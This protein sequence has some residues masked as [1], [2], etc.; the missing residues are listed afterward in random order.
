MAATVKRLEAV[1]AEALD[2]E[3]RPVPIA[4][5]A[6]LKDLSDVTYA[7]HGARQPWAFPGRTDSHMHELIDVAFLDGSQELAESPNAW[8]AFVG[9][10]FAGYI[11]LS[12]WARPGY[13]GVTT[14]TICD[15]CVVPEFR[16]Q[17]VG[18]ALLNHVRA[19]AKDEDWDGLTADVWA[20]NAGS[21]ALFRSA[22]FA[23]D[24]VHY[25]TGPVRE[26][27]ERPPAPEVET[28][29]R[30]VLGNRLVLLLL[31][32]VAGLGWARLFF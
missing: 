5:K 25:R 9:E 27:K 8:A 4:L 26:P 15:I 32:L 17:G 21:D 18:T 29:W 23:P 7:E 28:V 3:I 14:V 20:G 19:Q 6:R 30:A 11:L 12:P 31:G 22:G 16:R 10:T 1:G 13:E 2:V 24:Y